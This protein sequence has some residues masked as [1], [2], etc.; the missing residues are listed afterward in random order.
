MHVSTGHYKGPELLLNYNLYDYSVDIWS[1]GCIFA[2]MLFKMPAF[3]QRDPDVPYDFVDQLE[4]I[5]EIL[6][7][8]PLMDYIS[9]YNLT[10]KSN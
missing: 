1:V 8:T 4:V 5:T 2:A 7:T 3:F 9:K 6:G 10:L